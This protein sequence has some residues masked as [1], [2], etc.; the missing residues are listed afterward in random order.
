MA[1]KQSLVKCVTCRQPVPENLEQLDYF[2][3]LA[4]KPEAD[5]VRNF[6]S[7]RESVGDFGSFYSVFQL[8]EKT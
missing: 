8:S 4:L 2:A 3:Q 7:S 5:D 1:A 6:G